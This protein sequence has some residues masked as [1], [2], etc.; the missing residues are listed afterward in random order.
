MPTG[1]G[2]GLILAAVVVFILVNVTRV[3]WLL[4]F[5]S[6]LWGVI[7]VSAVMPWLAMGRL[8]IRRR[9]IGWN[10]D[11]SLPG[12]EEGEPVKFGFDLRNESWLP[13]VFA[14]VDYMIGGDLPAE[15][16]RR[17]FVA[18]LGSG[19]TAASTPSAIYPTR[20]LHELDRVE[21]Q[22]SVP[23]GLFRRKKR[24]ED[25]D[26][27]LVMPKLYPV[28]PIQVSGLQAQSESIV[29]KTRSGGQVVGSRMYLPGDPWRQIHWRN[30]ARVGQPQLKEFESDSQRT[31][32]ICF[33]AG[34]DPQSA[35]SEDN[36]FE[37]A[38]R[39]AASIGVAACRTGALARIL[40]GPLDIV[41]GDFRELLDGLARLRRHG[42]S[43]VADHIETAGS[44]ATL[45]IVSENDTR[46]R[47]AMRGRAAVHGGGSM[48]M[49][50]GYD[51]PDGDD[52]IVDQP[53]DDA[54][55]RVVPCIMGEVA[56]TLAE[57]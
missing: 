55:I 49:M 31:F 45:A 30:T 24:F 43:T 28:E 39:I 3:G 2:I 23:F 15:A 56:Q 6:V 4:L 21:V 8:N 18:W 50:K 38:I 19:G 41:T 46:A 7:V 22:T 14:N 36:K 35:S 57:L 54:G 17:M 1:R 29:Q 48:I 13:L 11:E 25:S 53:V 9:V 12:P 37:D 44:D 51:S 5:D 27:V 52:S 42:M 20:G 34:A 47:D 26:E 33:D 40:A 16:H 10:G 32:T